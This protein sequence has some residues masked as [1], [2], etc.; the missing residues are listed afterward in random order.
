[1]A[2]RYYP[3]ENA[4]VDTVTPADLRA[5][6][7]ERIRL[8]LILARC[9]SDSYSEMALSK[10][11]RHLEGKEQDL[12]LAT[13]SVAEI[14][15]QGRRAV[16]VRNSVRRKLRLRHW[17]MQPS[18][19]V[20]I[21]SGGSTLAFGLLALCYYLQHHLL[22][23]L[24]LLISFCTLALVLVARHSLGL[25]WAEQ[26]PE[27]SAR[28]Q[29]LSA[30]VAELERQLEHAR[31][32][33]DRARNEY[34]S[35]MDWWDRLLDLARI[36]QEHARIVHWCRHLEQMLGSRQYHLLRENWNEMD[37]VAFEQFLKS[38]FEMLGYSA[39]MTPA[40]SDYGVDLIVSKGGWRVAIQAKRWKTN[41]D[42]KAIQEVFFGKN[43]YKCDACVVIAS[44]HF[45]KNAKVAARSTG[46][47]LLS[48]DHIPALIM[49]K[50]QIDG[51]PATLGAPPPPIPRR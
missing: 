12:R 17:V 49:G 37:G 15:R 5:A 3:W 11:R 32:Q 13:D 7:T 24:L 2:R 18:I 51:S 46:C 19:L 47:L 42:N 34:D 1:M 26:L 48:G 38:V 22:G 30:N 16:G 21:S 39:E 14:K 29:Q 25:T 27:L 44:S 33:A 9:R 23:F 20:L 10:F 45:T 4:D 41:V 36:S 6:N 28:L 35:A 8:E 40:T 31:S 50:I 43:Y